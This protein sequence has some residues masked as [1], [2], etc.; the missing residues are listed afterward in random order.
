MSALHLN[1][2]V[3]PS[4]YFPIFS[5]LP[6]KNKGGND[7]KQMNEPEKGSFNYDVKHLG[8]KKGLNVI[9]E[10]SEKED[11]P[12]NKNTSITLYSF[13]FYSIF[14]VCI[15]N[16]NVL[17]STMCALFIHNW[18]FDPF[19]IFVLILLNIFSFSFRR[20][21]VHEHCIELY[22]HNSLFIMPSSLRLS[23]HNNTVDVEK[24]GQGWRHKACILYDT[25]I[26]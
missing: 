20:G 4:K 10:W 12:S 16:D 22:N 21:W 11:P 23:T 26:K 14:A 1:C 17:K 13:N 9:S 24:G 6:K 7:T 25:Y 5:L 3:F 18:I 15:T 19:F 8:S 2:A